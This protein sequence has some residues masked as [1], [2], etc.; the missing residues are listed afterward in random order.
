MFFVLVFVLCCGMG[1]AFRTAKPPEYPPPEPVGLQD[2]ADLRQRDGRE[3]RLSGGL[4]PVGLEAQRL[5]RVE[6]Y[7]W[8]GVQ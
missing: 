3:G 1:M 8:P 7:G 6:R 4:G 2:P 5:D